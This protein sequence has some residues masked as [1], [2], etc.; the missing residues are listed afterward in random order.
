[1]SQQH[2]WT[3]T[4]P[5]G[6]SQ[7]T[8]LRFQPEEAWGTCL[9]TKELNKIKTIE[10]NPDNLRRHYK[11]LRKYSRQERKN[12][13]SFSSVK[14][15]LRDAPRDRSLICEN[16]HGISKSTNVYILFNAGQI[17]FANLGKIQACLPC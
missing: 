13:P 2:K 14:H 11:V 8:R 15:G 7:D 17:S 10:K 12:V 3:K 6:L 1:M 4:I 9:K 16:V 5:M